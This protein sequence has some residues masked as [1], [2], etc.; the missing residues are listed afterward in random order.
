MMLFYNKY[1]FGFPYLSEEKLLKTIRIF[2]DDSNKDICCYVNEVIFWSE[3]KGWGLVTMRLKGW[4]FS[5]S[6]TSQEGEG[7]ELDIANGQL[8]I[9]ECAHVVKPS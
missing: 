3:I 9:N 5:H 6:P 8:D 2:C 1:I 7:F 4:N